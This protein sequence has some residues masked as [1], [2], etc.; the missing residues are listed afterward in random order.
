[1]GIR[2]GEKFCCALCAGRLEAGLGARGGAEHP[3]VH[4]TFSVPTPQMNQG[5]YVPE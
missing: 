2:V 1:M 5:V 3:P 4:L